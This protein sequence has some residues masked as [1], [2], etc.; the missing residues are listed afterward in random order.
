[1]SKTLEA[2]IKEQMDNVIDEE[3]TDSLS[4]YAS[5][6]TNGISDHF[7]IENILE[8]TLEGKSIFDSPELIDSFK[9][10]FLYEVK[11]ALVVGIEILSICIIIGLLKNLSG[12]FGEKSISDIGT[13]T[14][15]IVI[16]GL[17]MVNF[18][19]VYV[20]TQD[21]I[22]TMTYTMEILLPVLIGILIAMG[23]VTS[24][25]IMSPLILFAIT[26][27]QH[28]IKNIVL[29]AIFI[30]CAF[31]LLNCLTEK[32]YVNHLAKFIRRAALFVT[33]LLIT[34]MSGIIS[35]QG[36]I[37]KTSDSLIMST[38]KYSLDSFIP[39][40][41]GFTANTIELF[42]KCMGSIKSI[43]GLFGI[44]LIVV[45]ILVPILKTVAI[46]L[47]YKMTAFLIEPIGTKKLAEGVNDI[48][49]T[50]ITLSAVLF[51]S[52]LLFILF[53]TSIM[54]LGGNT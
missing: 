53:I 4:E 2:L 18:Q 21:A 46:A 51:F 17:A 43:V 33:G 38:A 36:L 10:L 23:Q 14:C 42:L 45:M 19:D 25:T 44:L 29:P 12:S 13:L 3:T 1:M 6:L 31:T 9:Q 50:L 41:G 32:D 5:N 35:I 30:S 48:G 7:T 27:F 34:L 52:S 22:K 40:V 26:I 39:I 54:N 37:T 49:T 24:G 16:I 28:I 20:M 47:I 11:S 15:F 8:A